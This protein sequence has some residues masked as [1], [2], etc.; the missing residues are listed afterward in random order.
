[1]L[2]NASV[3]ITFFS[4][5][6]STGGYSQ[7]QPVIQTKTT[8]KPVSGISL[9]ALPKTNVTL[10]PD[11]INGTKAYMKSSTKTLVAS[12]THAASKTTVKVN[13]GGTEGISDQTTQTTPATDG[14]YTCVT[15]N[16]N[17]SVDYFRQPVF[18]LHNFVYPGAMFDATDIINNTFGYKSPPS[19]Y[20]RQPYRI[21]ANLFT[22]NGTTTQVSETI[23]D[24]A[25]EDYSLASYREALSKILN[26][27]SAANPP[28]EAF[29]EYIEATSKEEVAIK[30]GYNANANIPAEI[31]MMFTGIPVG[32]NANVDASVIANTQNEKSRLILKI[33]YNF[34]YVNASPTDDNPH[35]LMAPAPGSDVSNNLVFV[36][37]VLYGTTGYVYFESEKTLTELQATLVETFGAAGPLGEGE[38]NVTVSAETRAKFN[39][40]VSK[41][42]AYGRGLGVVPGSAINVTTLDQLMQLIGTLKN[43]GP[44]NQGT[45]IA[46]T[47]QFIKDNV[48]AVVSYNT[49]FPNKVCTAPDLSTLK[50]D[51][52]L[53][54]ES[55][56]VDNINSGMGSKEELYGKLMFTY[57]KAG[58]KEVNPDII[59]F[60]KSEDDASTNSFSKGKR[61]VDVKHS[62][63]KNLSLD[64]LRNITIHIAG[65]LKDDEGIFGSRVYECSDCNEFSG[66][67]GKRKYNFIEIPVAQN[68]INSLANNGTA[69]VLKFGDNEFLQMNF[70][71]SGKK[72]EGWVKVLW[73]VWVKPHQ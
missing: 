53:E 45:P 23:G 44:N 68:S 62:I 19:N 73:K 29:I 7:I 3:G 32:V 52:E 42:V 56:N 57:L 28:V 55:I 24:Q 5:L 60:N 12:K 4:L 54:L 9:T 37:S 43:W 47:M 65:D 25:G 11:Y 38:L 72:A 8:I 31:A 50:F 14:A 39:S 70:Y 59:F 49:Q 10:S 30:L 21:S 46:Y 34:F 20:T 51:V 40:T 69:Q 61:A 15:R 41:M 27:N 71:E 1:M 63:I 64:E 67:L 36:S 16:V 17:T 13:K 18:E 26:S 35:K 66:S 33:N 48:Q 22:M 58:S 6:L 2:N